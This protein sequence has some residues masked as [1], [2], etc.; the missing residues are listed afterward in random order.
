[1]RAPSPF[2]RGTALLVLLL[3]IIAQGALP[4][5]DAALESRDPALGVH[6]ESQS[7]DGCA[8]RHDHA[9]CG[10]CRALQTAASPSRGD[11]R[12]AYA[13]ALHSA[14]PTEDTRDLLATPRDPSQPRAPPLA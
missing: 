1:M 8:S 6:M 7:Q 11:A 3:Q 5:A 10:I 12:L 4:L 14:A 9:A 13:A 2:I